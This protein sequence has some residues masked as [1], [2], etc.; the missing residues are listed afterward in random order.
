MPEHREEA[1]LFETLTLL[2]KDEEKAY[3][4]YLRAKEN[5]LK[6]ASDFNALSSIK[7][8]FPFTEAEFF[9]TYQKV[10]S[11]FDLYTFDYTILAEDD[12]LF[13]KGL[14]KG[15]YPVHFLYLVGN[16]EL[17][18]KKKVGIYGMHLPSLQGKDDALKLVE[19]VK[20]ADAALVTTLDP[21]I[22]AFAAAVAEKIDLDII[23]VLQTPLHQCIPA[24]LKERMEYVA[25]EGGLLMTRF[26]PS[27]KVE[28]WHA[29][30]RN[31][32][33][34]Y[35]IDL[36]LLVEEKDGG[37]G[38]M[39]SKMVRDDNRDVMLPHYFVENTAYRYAE[40]NAGL[41]HALVYGKKGDLS[42]RLTE[43]PARK[44]K[45]TDD[46]FVQLSLF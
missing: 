30:L 7:S 45:K 33:F 6:R 2:V 11:A 9:A 19:E 1:I 5:G 3:A 38:W 46:G 39:L 4:L 41:N 27:R 8:L 14:A 20:S 42:K 43:K 13:P 44:E 32:L 35:S 16:K 29:V 12:E 37:P 26:A 40:R 18:R 36:M 22:P 17:L 31:R 34:V 21:G 23:L 24:E 25:N 28:K 15:E 10:A